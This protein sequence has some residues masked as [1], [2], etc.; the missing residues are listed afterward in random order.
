MPLVFAPHGK[1]LKVVKIMTDEKTKK[2]LEN[3]GITIGSAITV[4]SGSGKSTICVVKDSRLALDGALATQ[5]FVIQQQE[6]V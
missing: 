2:H 3:L 6:A 4:I 5:I 1:L